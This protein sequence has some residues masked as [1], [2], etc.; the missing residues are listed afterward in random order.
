MTP[1]TPT[2]RTVR[3]NA[4]P[5]A[6]YSSEGEPEALLERRARITR[7]LTD[8]QRAVAEPHD[9]A[10]L[11]RDPGVVVGRCPGQRRVEQHLTE[12]D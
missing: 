3:G 1:T 9:D 2:S 5:C 6:A 11:A 10:A 8:V 4:P 12:I 7:L